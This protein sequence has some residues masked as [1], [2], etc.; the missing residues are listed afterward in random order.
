MS[1]LH[2]STPLRA[3]HPPRPGSSPLPHACTPSPSPP[4]PGSIP[5]IPANVLLVKNVSVA[6]VYWGAHLTQDP[7]TLLASADT[8]IGWWLEGKLKPHV[9]ERLPLAEANR[10]FELVQS[11]NSTGKVVLMP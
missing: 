10:A 1:N 11:R 7:A 2:P 9:C 4:R 8:L 3:T 6:G 5:S